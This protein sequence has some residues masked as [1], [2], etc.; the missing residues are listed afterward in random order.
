MQEKYDIKIEKSIPRGEVVCPPS[1]SVAHRLLIA[2]SL[3]NGVSFIDNVAKSEDILATIDCLKVLGA[4]ITLSEGGAKV[5]GIGNNP[6]AKERTLY[7]RES[8]ST[9]RFLLPLCLDG[10]RTSFVCKGR[11]MQRPMQ[12]YENICKERGIF[13]EAKGDTLTVCGRLKSGVYALPANI[14]S[15]FITGLLFALPRLEGKSRIVFT[16]P[17]ESGS[18]LDLTFGTLDKFKIKYNFDRE[19]GVIDIPGKQSYTATDTVVEADH[20]N[21]AFFGALDALY[22]TLTLKGLNDNSAQGDRVWRECFEKIKKGNAKISIKDCPD[23]G[24]ILMTLSAEYGGAVLT[25]TKRLKIKESDRGVA[26]MEELSKF[27]AKIKVE[28][29]K[30]IIEKSDLHSPNVKLNSHNDHR[31]AM[32]LA[33]LCTLYGGEIEGAEAVNKSLPDFFDILSGL[34]VKQERIPR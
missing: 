15:Q 32:S 18:Y 20:S 28:E 13:Y 14:S 22:G 2:S 10:V 5:N 24:P 25:D 19:N 21:A 9:L 16:T 23:L 7:P 33:V 27:G 11:L 26:M 30:I 34:G 6:C 1:K 4:D 29:N 31:I 8:G 17:L 3:A 12:I